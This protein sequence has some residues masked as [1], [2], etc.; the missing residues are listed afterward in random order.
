M[1]YHTKEIN[2]GMILTNKN[3]EDADTYWSYS[4]KEWNKMNDAFQNIQNSG[5]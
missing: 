1:K 2:E 3:V 4:K 5:I